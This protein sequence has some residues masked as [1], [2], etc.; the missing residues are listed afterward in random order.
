MHPERQDGGR[1]I[2]YSHTV[3]ESKAGDRYE[4]IA[5]QNGQTKSS[6]PTATSL[7]KRLHTLNGPRAWGACKS[8]WKTFTD[9]LRK[10]GNPDNIPL[11]FTEK[12]FGLGREWIKGVLLCTWGAGLILAI[13]IILTVIAVGLAYSKP[14]SNRGGGGN[15]ER[16]VVYEGSCELIDRWKIGL[17]FLINVLSTGLLAVSNYVMQCLCAPSRAGVDRAHARNSWLDVGT[18]SL[19]NFAEMNGKRKVLWVVLFVSSLPIHM[20]FNSA[21]FSSMTAS[22]YQMAAIPADL[23]PDEPLVD[24]RD[25]KQF[26]NV[27]GFDPE[28]IRSDFLNGDLR[29]ISLDECYGRVDQTVGSGIGLIL[30]ATEREYSYNQSNWFA[31]TNTS[32][33][34]REVWKYRY[35]GS[36]YASSVAK[37]MKTGY[38]VSPQHWNYPVWSVRNSSSTGAD[39]SSDNGWQD[40]RDL[41]KKMYSL[42]E[43]LSTDINMLYN[44]IYIHNPD[45][46]ELRNLLA[47]SAIWHNE[48]WAQQLDVRIDTPRE[49]GVSL[50]YGGPAAV[51]P[52][53]CLVKKIDEH[54]ELYMSLPICLAVIACNIIKLVCMYLVARMPHKEI[55]LTVGD[56][57]ASFLDSP[58]GTTEG[59]GLM[60]TESDPNAAASETSSPLISWLGGAPH[61]RI[62][63]HRKRLYHAVSW[64]RWG[65]TI[66]C[67]LICAIATIYGYYKGARSIGSAIGANLGVGRQSMGDAVLLYNKSITGLI[68]LCNTPQL[69]LSILYYLCNGTLSTMLAAA[70][71]HAFALRRKPLRVSWPRGAQRST[72]YLSIP[73]RYGIPM[74]AV[75]TTLH[76]LLSQTFFLVL[77]DSRNA[78]QEIVSSASVGQVGFSLFGLLLTLVVGAVA[79]LIFCVLALRPLRGG[80]PLAGSCSVAI[81]AACHPPE[82]DSEASLKAVMWGEVVSSSDSEGRSMLHAL[83]L[84]EFS[85]QVMTE[86]AGMEYARCTF[87]SKDVV[88]PS[89]TR[90]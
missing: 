1:P 65:V 88:A 33:A 84:M 78:R 15:I 49:D 90:V 72:Y 56:A 12:H 42:D 79:L 14:S 85:N 21:V 60:S 6:R 17:H 71:Y 62:G 76:W 68:L 70:E 48:T 73:W 59:K 67:I 51:S 64:R 18:L 39:N 52:S 36:R 46:P 61:S 30:I 24:P 5:E 27:T 74:L 10:L 66:L 2:S 55:L 50:G 9:R 25:A 63:S 47:T 23:A 32:A 44:Y 87:T 43:P 28:E 41:Y 53:H 82:D 77:I 35:T 86:Q 54:C 69:V 20:L 3:T 80:M 11:P 58:D 57:V 40:Y 37:N 45:E 8:K 22:D 4:P 89:L 29:N 75:S 83:S 19:R 7:P 34:E 81:S 38:F 26:R 31:R 13:N 16:G